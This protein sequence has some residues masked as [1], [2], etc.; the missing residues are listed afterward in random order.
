MNV[1]TRTLWCHRQTKNVC[2]KPQS[3]VQF[4]LRSFVTYLNYQQHIL[5]FFKSIGVKAVL[6]G[7]K[8]CVCCGKCSKKCLLTYTYP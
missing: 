7:L 2:G 3:E 4:L 8:H 5:K 1:F 6:Y